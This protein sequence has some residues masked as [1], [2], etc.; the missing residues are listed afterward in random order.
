MADIKK[1]ISTSK[2]IKCL[3]CGKLRA[4]NSFYVNSN[5]LFSSEKFEVCKDCINEYIGNDRTSLGYLDRVKLVLA[6]LNKPFLIDQW[7]DREREWSKYIPQI[8]SF[9]QY[10]NLTFKDSVFDLITTKRVSGLNDNSTNN[11]DRH[12]S[13]DD[14]KELSQFWGKNYKD[15]DL[16]FLQDEFNKFINSYECDSYVMELLFHEAA[17]QRLT[18]K[19]LRQEGKSVEKE[20]KALQDLLGSANIKPSQETGSNATEQATF[21]TLIKKYENEKPIPEPDDDW[22]DVDNIKK[23]IQVWF[24]GHLCRMLGINNEYSKLYDEEVAR[25]TVDTPDYDDEIDD[26]LS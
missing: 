12:Y 5:P 21:G 4:N 13:M 9:P 11:S 20:L 22:K 16:E 26:G 1:E 15:E 8:S 2:K 7:E 3:N 17:Q 18:I 24:L 10:K 23:Y 25:Y 19:R 14:F 6:S